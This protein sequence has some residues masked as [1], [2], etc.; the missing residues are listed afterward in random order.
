MTTTQNPVLV[1]NIARNNDRRARG[2]W[3]L[4][5]WNVPG[6]MDGRGNGIP[7]NHAD[8]SV[9]A[10]RRMAHRKAHDLGLR[11]RVFV[12]AELADADEMPALRRVL[13]SKPQSKEGRPGAASRSKKGRTEIARMAAGV[14]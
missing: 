2:G 9:E 6:L 7:W 11:L 8:Q 13:R 12:Y 5:L 14:R 1:A 10:C 3:R 4:R